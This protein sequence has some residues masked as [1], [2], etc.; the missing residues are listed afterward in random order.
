MVTREDIG[1]DIALSAIRIKK[2]FE[3]RKK[4]NERLTPKEHLGMTQ[5]EWMRVVVNLE[6]KYQISI[7]QKDADSAESLDV[8]IETVLEKVRRKA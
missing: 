1:T 8:F 4:I 2:R 7:P 5:T 3:V 6:E